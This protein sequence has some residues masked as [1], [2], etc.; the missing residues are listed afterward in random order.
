MS[1][2][3]RRRPSSDDRDRPAPSSAA[4]PDLSYPED[5]SELDSGSTQTAPTY[6]PT[7]STAAP[8][9]TAG[10][11]ARQRLKTLYD[12][13]P[14]SSI[15]RAIA[16]QRKRATTYTDPTK[17]LLIVLALGFL[18]W[19]LPTTSIFRLGRSS[20]SVILSRHAKEAHRCSVCALH[21]G[22]IA[23]S[24]GSAAS[25]PVYSNR[26]RMPWQKEFTL[27]SRGKGVYLIT[28]EVNKEIQEGLKGVNVGLLTLFIK[29]TSASLSLNENYDPTVRSDMVKA[30]DHIVPE[31][32]G[33]EWEHV[34][35][36]EQRQATGNAR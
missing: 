17:V 8:T 19:I 13:S 14:H 36:G 12:D 26:D 29:H 18:A 30:V 21:A 5:F 4:A 32:G 28:S 6:P 35:E 16:R 7:R 10:R 23:D 9:D 22:H 15:D 25:N 31:Q 3:F 33:I 1:H 2:L 24:T 27:P 20:E 11:S 34:D